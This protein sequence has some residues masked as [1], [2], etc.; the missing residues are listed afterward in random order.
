M[1]SFL[2]GS[3]YPSLEYQVKHKRWF[4]ENILYPEYQDITLIGHSIGAYIG[5]KVA[6]EMPLSRISRVVGLFPTIERMAVTPNGKF[7]SSSFKYGRWFA[8]GA[9]YVLSFLPDR[10][11]RLLLR[12]FL[13]EDG[14]HHYLAAK[15]LLQY[16][17]LYNSLMMANDE[18][19]NVTEI[20]YDLLHRQLP[21]TI[22]YYGR[23]DLWCLESSYRD[24]KQRFPEAQLHLCDKDFAHAFVLRDA[25]SCADLVAGWLQD[26]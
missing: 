2:G 8:I 6:D 20:D 23:N 15:N 19:L 12:R 7:F 4:I 25:F 16:R 21:R 13:P 1:N 26:K 9:A 11:H 17:C 10:F 3:S 5:L 24:I 18:M 22:L 14:E